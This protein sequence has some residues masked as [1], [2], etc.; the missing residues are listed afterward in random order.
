MLG[1]AWRIVICADKNLSTRNSHIAITLRSELRH[2]FQVFSLGTINFF[3]AWLEF[4]FAEM[5][6]QTFGRRIHI[7]HRPPAPLRPILC[8][9]L[10]DQPGRK[11]P[12]HQKKHFLHKFLLL[13]LKPPPPDHGFRFVGSSFKALNCSVLAC[14]LEAWINPSTERS[15]STSGQC[16]P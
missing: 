8:A 4:N 15:S 16:I 13:L 9:N 14:P 6:G 5:I 2:P 3:S 12:S 7:A 1:I 10:V 11:N